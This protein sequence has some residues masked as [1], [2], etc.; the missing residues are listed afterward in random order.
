[1]DNKS[2]TASKMFDQLEGTWQGTGR[3]GYPTIAPFEYREKLVLTRRDPSTLAYEQRT[4]KCVEGSTEFVP[5]HW[6]S[7]FIR[8]LENDQ[9]ELVNVQSGGRG[10]VLT[11]HIEAFGS[12]TRLHFVSKAFMNDTRMVSSARKFELDGE[13]LHY[14]M[15]MSTTKLDQ[16]TQHLAISLERV[17]K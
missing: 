13:H 1:M 12:I 4:E 10:E 11:G 17:R 15:E 9:L 7:G 5:S 3:G 14:E 16:M 8:I 2:S 6:E